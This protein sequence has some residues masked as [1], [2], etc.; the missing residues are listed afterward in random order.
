MQPLIR[1]MRKQ[2]E[3]AVLSEL[4]EVYVCKEIALEVV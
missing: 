1:G 3:A 4:V 2:G